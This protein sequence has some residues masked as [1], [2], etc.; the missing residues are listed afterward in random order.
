MS[1]ALT[2]NQI[3]QALR[4]NDRWYI[5]FL[6]NASTRDLLDRLEAWQYTR[7]ENIE[8][9]GGRAFCELHID[10]IRAE[11]ARRKKY[12]ARAQAADGYAPK[13]PTA[14]REARFRERKDA[15]KA[16]WPIDLFVSQVMFADLKPVGRG[17]FICQCPFP[18]HQDD[19]PSFRLYPNDSAYCFGCQRGGDIFALAEIYFRLSTFRDVL[20]TLER[21]SPIGRM[22]S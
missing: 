8:H 12:L 7:L 16:R 19:S 22:A 1:S 20:D 2:T 3:R 15:I 18:D 6:R 10:D 14:D 5:E 4:N 11:L 21:L 17:E 13:W 9:E